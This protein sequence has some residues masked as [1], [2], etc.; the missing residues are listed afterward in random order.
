M[1]DI[2]LP[3]I[4][5][6]IGA[7]SGT[8]GAYVIAKKMLNTDSLMEKID[9]L[10][11]AVLTNE[12][13]QRKIYTIGA[14]VGKGIA[15]GTGIMNKIPSGRGKGGIVGSIIQGILGKFLPSEEGQQ[16]QQPS[17]RRGDLG[18]G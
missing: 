12:Q 1:E 11:D 13:M 8:L 16:G 3:I 9:E 4:S 14:I 15:D 6:V 5:A 2:V 7:F 17:E 18:L 10:T